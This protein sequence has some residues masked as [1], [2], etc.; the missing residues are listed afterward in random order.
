MTLQDSTASFP[1]GT[2]WLPVSTQNRSRATMRGT[3]QS[4]WQKA[5]Q[6]NQNADRRSSGS[7]AAAI[8]KA[9]MH[10]NNEVKRRGRA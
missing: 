3:L 8:E 2:N 7:Q 6:Q 9:L 1:T 10:W 5:A 4:F